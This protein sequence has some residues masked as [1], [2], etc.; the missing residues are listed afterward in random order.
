MASQD[1]DTRNK[2][3]FHHS[4]G[5]VLT[6]ENNYPGNE[7]YKSAHNVRSNETWIGEIPYAP[8]ATTAEGNAVGSS[9]IKQIGSYGA[10]VYMYPL[11][12]TNYQTWFMDTGTPTIANDGFIPS[13]EWVK[14]LISPLDVPDTDG[15]PSTG[16]QLVL[17]PQA[18]GADY[19]DRITYSNSFYE[20]DYFSGLIRFDVGR[21]PIDPAGSSGL[22]FQ[23]NQSA[24]E[25]S[26]DKIAY[27][28]DPTTGG[29]RAIAFQYI[30]ETV[31][32]ALLE[33]NTSVGDLMGATSSL[34]PGPDKITIRETLKDASNQD[35][36]AVSGA[37]G[38]K[39]FHTESTVYEDKSYPLIGKKLTANQGTVDYD[40]DELSV[41]FSP[42]GDMTNVNDLVGM[43]S[44]MPHQSKEDGKIYPHIHWSQTTTNNVIFELDY[45]IQGN[46]L[47]KTTAWTRMIA[48]ATDSAFTYTSGTLNQITK[49]KANGVDY[50]DMTGYG[51]SATVQFKMTRTDSTTGNVEAMFQD[52]H[53]EIDDLGSREEFEK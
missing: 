32:Q 14:P 46:N 31:D 33:L 42:G 8:D 53:Y 17:F 50:I 2:A 10:Q 51:I 21:T 6:E 35:G 3:A 34:L 7:K 41:I 19:T 49:F 40:W 26:I 28:N 11:T 16:Y 24:F 22:L 15:T 23:F 36:I 9:I 12:R 27:I 25:A 13:S 39:P 29:V 30:G 52:F 44:E 37:N 18:G 45:R 48:N 47:E 1:I 4:L 43:V 20:F 38:T 5:I